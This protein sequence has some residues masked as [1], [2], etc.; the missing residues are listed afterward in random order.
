[1][2]AGHFHAPRQVRLVEVPEPELGDE[3]GQFIFEPELAC[4]CGSDLPYFEGNF[5]EFEP[6]VGQSLH[7]MIG[8]VVATTGTRFQVGERVLCVPDH[9]YGLQQRFKSPESRAIPLDPRAPDDE[10]LMAQPLGT[11]LYALRKLPNLLGWNVAVIGQ[12]PMGQLICSALRNVGAARII[13]IEPVPERLAVSP[14]MGATDT[15]DPR[16]VE[17]L[18]AVREITRGALCDLVVEAVGHREQQLNLAFEL[19]RPQGHVLS[20]GVPCDQIDGLNYGRMF[21]KNLHLHTTVGPDFTR[22]FPLAMQWIA[23][24]RVD[25]RPI[26]THRFTLDKLQEA[27]D[28]FWARRD[29]VLKALVEFPRP[30]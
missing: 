25:V 23:E 28:L 5:P 7:E 18:E 16:A 4:L 3:P 13:A 17:P 1:M 26:L 10:A 30:D 6:H 21:W 19:C 8:R 15:I 2:L 29:G 27:F 9:H 24:A 12:G 14:R 20:F 11:V 22:D